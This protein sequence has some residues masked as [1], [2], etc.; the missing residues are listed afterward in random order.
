ME[1]AFK[2]WNASYIDHHIVAMPPGW[3]NLPVEPYTFVFVSNELSMQ[4]YAGFFKCCIE[5]NIANPRLFTPRSLALASIFHP[6]FYHAVTNIH[7]KIS[8]DFRK[9]SDA[10]I[11]L[12]MNIPVSA[13]LEAGSVRHW[14]QSL[15]FLA[16]ITLSAAIIQNRW[17]AGTIESKLNRLWQVSAYSEMPG[18]EQL[19]ELKIQDF[20]LRCAAKLDSNPYLVIR[21][22]KTFYSLV[23]QKLILNIPFVEREMTAIKLTAEQENRYGFIPALK[24]LLGNNLK[25][26][27]LYGS[28]V[29]SVQFADY[30]LVVVVK[31]LDSALHTL[32]GK[33]PVYNGLEL[34][35]SL[36]GETDFQTY[37]LVSGDNLADHGLCLYGSVKVP[38]KP[39][40]DLI[41]RNFSFGFIRFRQLMG[42]AAT[43]SNYSSAADDKRN[44][45]D[46]FIKIP[47]NVYKGIQ[48]C[49]GKPGTNEELRAWSVNSLNFDVKMQQLRAAN[50][51]AMESAASAAWATLEVMHWFDK[52][53]DILKI[54]SPVEQMV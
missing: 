37:Q 21:E 8:S 36:F 27:I 40:A 14:L 12:E 49:Y 6:S 20:V 31:D 45:L 47:L 35:I 30:D 5:N 25:A 11:P 43:L 9:F 48:G 18:F 34:N 46:Y 17:S 4:Q 33:S 22:L 53:M 16:G 32:A 7:S 29:N 39:A 13:E 15:V 19:K 38:Q 1:K 44:L 23:L 54:K 24:N 51:G 2:S 50:G 10:L 28:A 42:M 41:L 52:K 3:K 26:V